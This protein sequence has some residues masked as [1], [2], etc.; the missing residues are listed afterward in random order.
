MKYAI[1]K[2]LQK[3][4]SLRALCKY[5]R[6]F[7]SG[8]YKWLSTVKDNLKDNTLLLTK[9]REIYR[10][11]RGSYGSPRVHAQLRAWG[12]EISKSSVERIMRAY[13]IQGKKRR[14]YRS[15]T[16]SKHPR[17]IAPHLL[18]RR[19]D[20]GAPNKVWLADITYLKTESGFAYLAAVLDG[21][22]RK[23]VGW[24]LSSNLSTS[25]V[26]NALA[27]ATGREHPSPGLT[28]HSDRGSQYA[29]KEYRVL[30]QKH[31]MVQS[32]S[33]KGNCWDN[34][35][36]ES[37]FDTLKCEHLKSKSFRN[38]KEVRNS[39]FEWIEVFYNRKR[40]HSS[41][42]YQTPACIQEGSLRQE[43]RKVVHF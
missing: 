7:R 32:M 23:V 6:V 36:M 11:S 38:L 26:V 42:G 4:H 31:G 1:I 25:L 20:R 34:A 15:C 40:L 29:S 37:F 24:A 2:E 12:W 9:V 13:N 17:P 33:R 22:S 21:H 8:Y 5:L 16:N 10:S 39:I 30:L 3:E 18:E 27:M 41:L 14:S 28:C 43:A 19:F 35:P